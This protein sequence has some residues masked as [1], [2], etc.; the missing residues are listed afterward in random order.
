MTKWQ[1]L[2][3]IEKCRAKNAKLCEKQDANY[4]KLLKKLGI[5]VNDELAEWIWDYIYNHAE[6]SLFVIDESL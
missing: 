6:Y 1:K 4:E 3:A 2:Q 5:D